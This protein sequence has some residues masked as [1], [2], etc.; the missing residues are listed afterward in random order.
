MDRWDT[1]TAALGMSSARDGDMEAQDF[2]D[3]LRVLDQQLD[4]RAATFTREELEQL[5]Q[6]TY[7]IAITLE[8]H[9]DNLGD[10]EGSG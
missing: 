6:A 7:D 8:V 2:L 1:A 5:I 3:R 10:G 9:K 4:Y